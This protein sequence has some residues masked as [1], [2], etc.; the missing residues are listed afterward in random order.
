M[1]EEKVSKKRYRA[2]IEHSNAGEG[3]KY[4]VGVVSGGAGSAPEFVL[5]SKALKYHSMLRA[6]F[7]D[8][9]A[10]DQLFDILGGGI[11]SI[12]RDAK[13]IKTWGMSGGYGKPNREFVEEILKNAPETAGYKMDVTVSSYI[14]D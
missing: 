11:L 6:E 3:E 13:K 9:L 4:I 2:V 5:F 12:D 7:D 14:R 8:S 10:N 1:A